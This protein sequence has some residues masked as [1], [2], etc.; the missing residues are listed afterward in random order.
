MAS[1]SQVQAKRLWSRVGSER[2]GIAAIVDKGGN[3]ESN[4]A[5]PSPIQRHERAP[6]S[7]G[8]S[9]LALWLGVSFFICQP[10]PLQGGVDGWQGALELHSLP[11]F[12]Q[13]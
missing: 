1:C 6:K 11:Q 10:H 8:S 4:Q 7:R 12:L 5:D 3:E 13:C 2:A 9:R